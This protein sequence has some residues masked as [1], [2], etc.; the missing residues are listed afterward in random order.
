MDIVTLLSTDRIALEPEVSSKKR[1]FETLSMLLAK[2]ESERVFNHEGIFDSLFSREKLGS[3]ALGNG[4]AIPHA[5]MDIP[6]PKA[7]LLVLDEGIKMDAPDKKPVHV[8]LGLLVP[9]SNPETHHA[10]LSEL[11]LTINRR[12]TASHIRQL[13]DPELILD[14]LASLFV[15]DIAA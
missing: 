15:R 9:S 10:M 7:A 3:T 1:A 5:C 4:I 14:F 8:L 12:D 13:G 6:G 2:G 11:A